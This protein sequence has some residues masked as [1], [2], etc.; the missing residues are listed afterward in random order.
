MLK[1]ANKKVRVEIGDRD[2]WIFTEFE[3]K[4]QHRL[5][6]RLTFGTYPNADTSGAGQTELL[7]LTHSVMDKLS[8]MSD[9][10][11]ESIIVDLVADFN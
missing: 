9:D 2:I 7:E 11:F 5:K 4:K 1:S 6:N 8:T 3:A 10:E